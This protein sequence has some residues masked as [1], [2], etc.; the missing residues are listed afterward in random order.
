MGYCVFCGTPASHQPGAL[1]C[2]KCGKPLDRQNVALS[3]VTQPNP[4]SSTPPVPPVPPVPTSGYTAGS[5]PNAFNW[6]EPD[7]AG[8]ISG[9]ALAKID[10][11]PY[12]NPNPNNQSNSYGYRQY[13]NSQYYQNFA[14]QYPPPH[15]TYGTPQP[16]NPPPGGIYGFPAIYAP[17]VMDPQ[18]EIA[19]RRK[20]LNEAKEL[21]LW[22]T[23]TTVAFT[24]FMAVFVA[25][26]SYGAGRYVGSAIFPIILG[27]I[28]GSIVEK[29]PKAGAALMF[30]GAFFSL[31][32]APMG[33]VGAVL[34]LIGAIKAVTAR[35]KPTVI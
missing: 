22:A 28:A 2:S 6:P 31:V 21:A 8:Q 20:V 16:P 11:Y 23:G 1:F 4:V 34:L 12:G 19:K 3:N 9:N 17:Y 30:I 14:G 25:Y 33:W 18:I 13:Q 24:G 10:P 5:N 29:N 7:S 32:A 35:D 15:G 26:S 27:A